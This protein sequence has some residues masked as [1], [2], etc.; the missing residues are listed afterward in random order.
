MSIGR[1]IK[2]LERGRGKS[3]T[4]DDVEELVA[5]I[6]G[7]LE[8]TPY[9]S[10]PMGRRAARLEKDWRASGFRTRQAVPDDPEWPVGPAWT[11][12]QA[13]QDAVS[14]YVRIKCKRLWLEDCNRKGRK[15]T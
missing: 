3:T 6:H 13:D 12:L 7:S 4:F 10:T 5:L 14:F 2:T 15:T 8:G 11:D 9:P 1:R